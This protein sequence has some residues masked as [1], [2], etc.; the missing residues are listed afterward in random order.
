MAGTATTRLEAGPLSVAGFARLV[1][2][3]PAETRA[4]LTW[5]PT[6]LAASFSTFLD[7]ARDEVALRGLVTDLSRVVS[8]LTSAVISWAQHP[9]LVRSELESA[10][11][12]ELSVLCSHVD[13]ETADAAEWT[14]RA[15]IALSDFTLMFMNSALE[16]VKAVIAAVDRAAL[17]QS[18]ADHD[19]P[20]RVQALIM[21]AI[22]GVRR[23]KPAEIVSDLVLRAFDEID[24]VV[25][26]LQAA[27]IHLDPFK[28]ETLEER[29]ERCSRYADHIR[30]ALS[31]E[32]A[33]ALDDSRLRSL[34]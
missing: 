6:E 33:R 12:S 27:G 34:R 28:G 5:S 14:I 29:A 9:E 32:D 18:M 24:H 20:L 16:D 30:N 13:P 22:E 23:N 3:L 31:D 25:A 15:W 8:S 10:W 1:D 17:E 11:R 2:R 21:A 19:S 7:G 26:R 4:Q